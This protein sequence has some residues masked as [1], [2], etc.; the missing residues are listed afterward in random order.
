MLEVTQCLLLTLVY[1]A[2]CN[3]LYTAS[4]SFAFIV[5]GAM[6]AILL[7]LAKSFLVSEVWG[8]PKGTLKA[9]DLFPWNFFYFSLCCV[10]ISVASHLLYAS[11]LKILG[12]CEFTYSGKAGWLDYHPTQSLASSHR[13]HTMILTLVLKSHLPCDRPL[14]SL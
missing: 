1:L 11:Y 2:L 13:P 10:L 14:C 9:I 7:A 6:A 5:A 8:S 3:N 4:H 12:F